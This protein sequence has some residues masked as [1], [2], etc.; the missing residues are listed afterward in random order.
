[1]RLFLPFPLSL[2]LAISFLARPA[3][4]PSTLA[5]DAFFPDPGRLVISKF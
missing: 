2:L 1:M 3:I 4:S 5:N